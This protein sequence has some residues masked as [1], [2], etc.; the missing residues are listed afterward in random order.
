MQTSVLNDIHEP[1]IGSGLSQGD[2][3]LLSDLA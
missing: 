1:L 2:P 3:F